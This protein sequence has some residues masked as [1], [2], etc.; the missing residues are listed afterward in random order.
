MMEIIVTLMDAQARGQALE[1]VVIDLLDKV[2]E[3]DLF[4]AL[5]FLG[6]AEM[7]FWED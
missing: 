2:G 6:R 5:S 1:Q 4:Y 3:F 7:K